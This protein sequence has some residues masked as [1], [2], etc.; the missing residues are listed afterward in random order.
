MGG[1]NKAISEQ[2]SPDE[3]ADQ[4][5]VRAAPL[6]VSVFGLCVVCA[7]LVVFVFAMLFGGI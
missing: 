4:P 6:I 1:V 7:I 3:H 2:H 5:V